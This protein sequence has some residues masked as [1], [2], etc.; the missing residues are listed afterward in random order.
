MFDIKWIRENAAA[1]DAGLKK[2]GLE[3]HSKKLIELDDARRRHLTKLQEA[4]SRRNAASKEIGKAKADKDEAAAAKLMAEMTELKEIIQQGEE[5]GMQSWTK[6][7]V[8]LIKA[9]LIDRRTA[10]EYAPN[11]DALEMALKGISFSS[12]SFS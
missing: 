3:P 9:E 8:D 11:R 10:R 7:F 6:S 12:S 1:F 2:R 5:E 4:Q